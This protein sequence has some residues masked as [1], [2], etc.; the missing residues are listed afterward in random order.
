[1]AA[2]VVAGAGSNRRWSASTTVAGGLAAA[3]AEP[4]PVE[5]PLLAL[6][7]LS[8]ARSL[9][10]LSFAA[11]DEALPD[12]AE[13]PPEPELALEPL[14][15]PPELLLDPPA[16]PELLFEAREPESVDF[17]LSLTSLL[18]LL[19]LSRERSDARLR[20]PLSLLDLATAEPI[21]DS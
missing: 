11:A 19:P 20:S 12:A 13:L 6:L 9:L 2:G 14:L 10:S 5:P 16:L 18:P 3:L 15:E 1:V 7:L 8:A 4:A 21:G 17:E